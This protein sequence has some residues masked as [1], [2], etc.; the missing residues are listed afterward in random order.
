MTYSDPERQKSYLRQYRKANKEKI[1]LLNKL[2]R[3]NHK[4][5]I[6][7]KNREY[8]NT[9]E[10]K[11]IN[12]CSKWRSRGIIFFDWDLLYDI[13]IHTTHCDNCKCKLNQCNSS[14][15]CLDHDHDITD[16]ENVRGILCMRCNVT[17]VLSQ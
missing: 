4:E 11:K 10:G 7:Q 15:K 13:Y 2:W 5:Y 3:N 9:P 8:Y 17:D 1:K 12:M 6:S 16:D 14:R